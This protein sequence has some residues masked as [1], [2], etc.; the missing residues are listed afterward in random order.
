MFRLKSTLLLAAT[1]ACLPVNAQSLSDLDAVTGRALFEKLWVQAPSSTAASDGLGPYYN[2]RACAACHANGGRGSITQGRV[3]MLN[4]PDYGQQ[5]Q[6]H[7][8]SGLKAEAALEWLLEIN[9]DGLGKPV[10]SLRELAHGDP[11]HVYSVRLA[12]GLRG[13]AG[14]ASVPVEVLQ[15]LAD[16]DD[17]NQDGISGRVAWLNTAE[18]GQQV[19]RYGWKASEATLEQQIGRA[20]SLD[21]GLGNPLYPDPRGDCTAVQAACLAAPVGRDPGLGTEV[22]QIVVDLLASYLASLQPEASDPV[23]DAGYRLFSQS[24]CEACH[25]PALP[26]GMGQIKAWSDLLLHDMGAGLADS[27]PVAHAL[28]SEWRTAPLWGMDAGP[29]LHDGR[30]R[31]LEEAI[32]WHGG[33]GAAARAA[34]SGLNELERRDLIDFLHGL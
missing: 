31:T 8:V 3:L 4:D 10:P 33:E 32:L 28:P 29:Y 18:G 16:P 22:E 6:T 20:L 7:A 11:G 24:G 14:F 30:A 19:G 34:F 1:W 25:I 23:H 13:I 15:S 5:L 21:L 27:L 17:D 9:A 12:P 26:A 2:A